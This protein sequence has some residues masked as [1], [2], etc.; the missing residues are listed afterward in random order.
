[1][2]VDTH[3]H[4]DLITQDEQELNSILIQCKNN[5]V[6]LLINVSVDRASNF[7]NEK[8]AENH[9]EIYFSVG[10]HPHEVDRY[11]AQDVDDIE[12]ICL[13]KKCV[14]I[15][16]VGID[17]FHEKE[18]KNEQIALFERFLYMA[19]KYQKPI[20]IHSRNAFQEVFEII[21]KPEFNGISGV[22]HCFSY[23]WDEA[24]KCIDLG[25]KISFAGNLT[26]KNSRTIQDTA[27]RIS[28]QEVFLETDAPFLAP[29]PFRGKKNFP[30]YIN[31]L[32]LFL[33]Q[34]RNEDPEIL[35]ARLYQ[36][37]TSFFRLYG[38]KE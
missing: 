2:I 37:V 14:A 36:N 33:S 23:G 20:I 11:S 8:M 4:L 9:E 27:K 15:G 7:N 30:Y 5:K 38:N 3:C 13:H 19:R 6:N 35:C 24:L 16:E 10:L 31:H 34:L 17:L 29:V 21:R 22:F 32:A 26:Y 28:V 25:Y 18:K 1:M 12:K